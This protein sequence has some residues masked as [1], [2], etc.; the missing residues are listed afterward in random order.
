MTQDIRPLA[1][2]KNYAFL[3]NGGEMGDLIMSYDWSK[4]VIGPP[5]EWPQSLRTTL[6][7]VLH[8]AFPMFLFW[9]KELICFY[10]DAF[11]PSLGIDGK[12][13]AIGKEGREV[14]PEIW[15]FI[16][17]LI[18]QVMTTGKPVWFED[19]LVPFYRNGR[20]EDIYW[21]FSYSPAYGDND[22]INGVFVTCTET[23]SK[24][25]TIRKLVESEGRFRS[26]M[27]EAPIGVVVL[28]GP[29]HTVALVNNA[30]GKLIGRTEEELVGK[31]LFEVVPETSHFFSQIIESVTDNK[32]SAYLYD[33]P[34]FVWLGEEKKTGYL[35]IVCQTYHEGDNSFGMMVLCSDV[36]EQVLAREKVKEAEFRLRSIVESAPFPIAV[37]T[38][39]EMRIE[40]A[41]QAI[42]DVW[43]KGNDVVGK[44]YTD[45]LPELTDQEI[46]SQVESVYTT[47]IP[48]HGR[49]QRV[50]LVV[51]GKLQAYYFNY[52]FTPLYDFSGNIYGVMNTAAEITDL[53]LAKQK[54]EQSE[55]NLRN[56]I[57]QSP[58]AMCILMGPEH[59]VEVAN[60]LIIELWG[61]TPEE[62]LH[63]PV[64]EGLPDAREQGL[65]QIL[66]NVY[67][68]G[69]RFIGKERQVALLRKG[70]GE[71]L[72]LNF[73]YEP[74]RDGDGTIQGIMAIA[75][76]VTEQV[77][78]RHK[79]EEIVAQRTRE[80]AR[81]NDD[82]QRS[83]EELAQF[84]YIAS[85]DLQEPLRKIRTF[86]QM[87]ENNLEEKL[88]DSAR[89]YFKKINTSS[90]RMHNL[91]RDLLDYSELMRKEDVYEDVNLNQILEQVKSD[92]ELLME[93]KGATIVSEDLPT[94]RAIPLQ[95]SQLFGNLIGNALKFSKTGT[96]P[97]ITISAAV[98]VADELRAAGLAADRN[99]VRLRFADN[100][101]G[102]KK[103]FSDRIFKIFQ[104]LHRKSE[105]EG[106]GIGL[107][108]CKKIALT[109]QGDINASGSSENGAVF[110]V[111]LPVARR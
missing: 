81:V 43:G 36:T 32:E 75:I 51:D 103:E 61:K 26:L 77:L 49:N 69:E 9:G 47:G 78:A 52:S 46:F 76:D 18:D 101:I 10:N 3:E 39:K 60:D 99:Y 6:G 79:I 92:Y 108:M 15:S 56:M 59:V 64:F 44:L 62:V 13:P 5:E 25:Q 80:L 70:V 19:Q 85:H 100:G 86:S 31:A 93:Q 21:T 110:N 4:S 53:N 30:F 55:R 16:G 42:M 27:S 82:L 54:I 88:D 45:V 20:M 35:N 63:K 67:N 106:T 41:N 74:Y 98:P 50:D 105:Y 22:E 2:Q 28:S 23:T 37:Y 71:L 97:V 72:Y 29:Q 96:P 89:N 40:L 34:Y 83:N 11:R 84:A 95:M 90:T 24:V 111:Y 104:R 38:G 33:H 48:F 14:W 1:P 87:L 17:P 68:T 57:L 8:S 58:V 107:A 94:I 109:H 73:V 7:I 12:H 66:D 91:I 102:I 65:E